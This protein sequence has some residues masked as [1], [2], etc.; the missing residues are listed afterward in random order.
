MRG[1]VARPRRRCNSC[2]NSST[3]PITCCARP[4]S[5]E[6]RCRP[7]PLLRCMPRREPLRAAPCRASRPLF[8]PRRFQQPPQ[9]CLMTTTSLRV[10]RTTLPPATMAR[11]RTRTRRAQQT[12]HQRSSLSLP[13][14]RPRGPV[15]HSIPCSMSLQ[16]DWILW[17]TCLTSKNRYAQPS[18]YHALQTNHVARQVATRSTVSPSSVLRKTKQL[19][20]AGPASYL[21][22]C[23]DPGLTWIA[24]RIGES[25]FQRNA[26]SMITAINQ[27]LKLKRN[28][29]KTRAPDPSP[30]LAAVYTEGT[31]LNLSRHSIALANNDL[32]QQPTLRRR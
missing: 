16:M 2:S 18:S 22:P 15:P 1:P 3:A 13:A 26:S 31:M 19:N 8:R 23:L 12:Q 27:K 20:E 6:S 32:L 11:T 4:A 29:N 28:I 17:A 9:R 25:T 5:P 14:V 30:E 21:S 10:G 24:D 7:R